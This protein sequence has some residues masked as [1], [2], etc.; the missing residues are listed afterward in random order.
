MIES[1]KD[2]NV[3]EGFKS[4][5]LEQGLENDKVS[6][7][8]DANPRFLFDVF[9]END[10]I[11]ET[12]VFPDNTFSCKIGHQATTNFWKTRK[13]SEVFAIEAALEILEKKLTITEE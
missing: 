1:F 12:I 10:V 6:V 5:M 7:M 13:E 4:F 3:P 2:E 8:I 9:D 11:I